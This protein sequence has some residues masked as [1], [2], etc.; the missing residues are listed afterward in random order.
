MRNYPKIFLSDMYY[1]WIQSWVQV[2]ACTLSR[3]L[4]LN[5]PFFFALSYIVEGCVI[6]ISLKAFF[7]FHF[8]YQL[9]EFWVAWFVFFY[10]FIYAL[11]TSS[12]NSAVQAISLL[13]KKGVPETNI[14]FLNL[15][16]VSYFT[17]YLQLIF[18]LFHTLLCQFFLKLLSYKQGTS[19]Y[20]NKNWDAKYT[21]PLLTGS[22]RSACSLQAFP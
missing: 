15:I 20:H 2:C 19:N 1:Y 9:W 16:S 7:F 13:L 4:C 5:S 11:V 18:F 21:S 3:V 17:P 10:F 14:I 6:F 8:N 12:G 22:S